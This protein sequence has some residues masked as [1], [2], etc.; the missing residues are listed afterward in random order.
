MAEA[1]DIRGPTH[2]PSRE[3]TAW[4]AEASNAIRVLVVEDE[5]RIC[6][7]IED[8]FSTAVSR[9]LLDQFGGRSRGRRT[10]R[11]SSRRKPRLAILDL[12]LE[13]AVRDN[14]RLDRL[15]G[16]STAGSDGLVGGSLQFERCRS[17]WLPIPI[18]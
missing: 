14:E 12:R 10:G 16:V 2:L 3:T 8:A 7:L 11:A 1:H 15:P 5:A 17:G 13:E 6:S 9:C 18:H 4:V